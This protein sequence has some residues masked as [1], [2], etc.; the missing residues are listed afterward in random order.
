M[1]LD[2]S[3]N[4]LVYKTS[5]SKHVYTLLIF[6]QANMLEIV[7]DEDNLVAKY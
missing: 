4:K 1:D 7:D 3:P 6:E 2:L 5:V